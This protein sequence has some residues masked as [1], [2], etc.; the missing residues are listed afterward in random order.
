M[1]DQ[2][3]L[4]KDVAEEDVD[5]VVAGIDLATH[6]LAAADDVLHSVAARL[7]APAH[8]LNIFLCYQLIPL[9]NIEEVLLDLPDHLHGLRRAVESPPRLL[10][11]PNVNRFRVLDDLF[12][13]QRGLRFGELLEKS[14]C[15]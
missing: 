13:K 11:Q 6:L 5:D 15:R 7:A 3:S 8:R 10:E 14:V 2:S 4:D 9:P 1:G 12:Q